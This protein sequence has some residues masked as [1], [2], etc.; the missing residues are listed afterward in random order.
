[1]GGSS[2]FAD[3]D[4]RPAELVDRPPAASG[5]GRLTTTSLRQ[6]GPVCAPRAESADATLDLRGGGV[7]AVPGRRRLPHRRA[8][9]EEAGLEQAAGGRRHGL[10]GANR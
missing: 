4:G 9:P 10:Q 2:C 7:P 6:A 5:A 1:M 3:D 8:L